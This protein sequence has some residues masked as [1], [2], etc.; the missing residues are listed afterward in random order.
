MDTNQSS[1]RRGRAA[2]RL[3]TTVSLALALGACKDSNV[4]FLTAPTSVDNSPT[5][6]QNA[7]TG[8]IAGSRVDIGTYIYY[9]V[10]FARDAAQISVINPE[11]VTQQTGQQPIFAG[12]VGLWDFE[13]RNVGGALAI[14]NAV[15]RVSPAFTPE[16]A[17]ATIGVAQTIEAFNLMLLAES[18]DTL[19]IP[20]HRAADGGPGPVF[21]NKDAWAGI[22]ALLDTANANLNTA[23]SI[24][25]PFALPGGF[26]SASQAAGPST[27]AG[28]FAS[29][30][31]ALAA[32]AGLELAYAIAR[33][34]PG[35]HPTPGTPG[36][37][38]V[39]ALT[40]ADSAAGASALFNLAALT[41]PAAGGFTD[42]AN[43]VYLDFNAQSNDLVNPINGQIG[44]WQLLRTF[45]ADVDT[46]HD[47]RWQRRIGPQQFPL[48]L[49][50]YLPVADTANAY[51]NYPTTNS[52]IPIIRTESLVLIRAQ[53]QLGLGNF[54]QA[55]AY[56]N[57]VR[58][59]VGGLA[60]V[61]GADYL[62]V[63]NLLL[64]EQR[65]STVFEAS[66]DRTIALR[67]YHLE[68][69][70]DTTWGS[71]DLH[72]TVVPVEQAELAGRNN[73]YTLTCN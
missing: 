73:N 22:V 9:M 30:N 4:P 44:I 42:D 27:V 21:C 39:A 50:Q 15:P 32:K 2:R 45:S 48:Q 12:G 49:A 59:G 69:A 19:G 43:G 37:P 55:I 54:G 28:T 47:L 16:Q 18:R 62:T 70:A 10:G 53:I 36:T 29:F 17:A 56:I 33:N 58:T 3:A 34:S 68:A 5:G 40:R 31:R 38:D 11:N 46:A 13:Y 66:S 1:Q 25:L 61:A 41:P 64:K 72:T 57:A 14:I 26:S 60:A 52:P 67:M 65:I 51:A 7:M 23:G 71:A 35:T 8:L 20:I 63:R 6:I 24:P